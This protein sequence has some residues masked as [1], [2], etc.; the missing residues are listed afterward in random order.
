[1]IA[2]II[3]LIILWLIGPF[4]I[5]TIAKDR[6]CGFEKAFFLSILLSP[7]FGMWY[8]LVSDRKADV[9]LRD[10]LSRMADMSIMRDAA[11]LLSDGVINKEEYSRMVKHTDKE[12]TAMKDTD[13]E[14]YIQG[15]ANVSTAPIVIIFIVTIVTA[16]FIII[17]VSLNS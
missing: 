12:Q 4:V 13:A 2:F 16:I 6:V 14:K 15:T 3:I 17:L 8:V 7:L 11:E 1:M 5:G 10:K 9:E